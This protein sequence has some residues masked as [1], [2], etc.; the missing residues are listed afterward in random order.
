MHLND[1]LC[2]LNL[3]PILILRN[4]HFEFCLRVLPQS[5]FRNQILTLALL[6]VIYYYN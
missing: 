1:E 4:P 3:L 5:E 2:S 6:N